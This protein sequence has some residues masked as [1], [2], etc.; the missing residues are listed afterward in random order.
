MTN[1]KRLFLL[2][3]H[4]LV[5]R[6][7]YA[8]ITR[9]LINSKGW[10]TSAITGFVRTIY[11]LINNQKPTHL[12]VSFDLPGGTFRDDMYP[13]YKANRDAQPEGITF[14]LP[15]IVKIL[16]AWKIPILTLPR[17]EADDVIGTIAKKAEKA[18]YQVF[19]VTPDKDYG[20]LVSPNIFMYKPGKAGG[21][22]EIW[23]EK[24]VCANWDIDNVDQ[25]VDILGL[26]GDAVDNIPGVR[27]VGPKAAT[28]LIREYADLEGVYAN[29]DGVAELELR[30]A[31][32]LVELLKT[33]REQAFLSR[34]LATL[35][36]EVPV[37]QTLADLEWHGVDRTAFD[38]LATEFGFGSG[39]R[40]RLARLPKQ[41]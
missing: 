30:G 14:G 24:E 20:Q 40:A 37:E 2:D 35:H 17:F 8:F 36:A 18:G 9:P 6:A 3:G 34:E 4:A 27:G 31:K 29:L 22:V 13:A 15:W 25:V 12:A 23:G 21:E 39:T 32:R 38:A 28:A 1:D 10:D 41:H 33:G 26:Q 16:K 19:M 7:H 5:Y 11:D